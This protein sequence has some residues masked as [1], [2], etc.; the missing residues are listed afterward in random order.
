MTGEYQNFV[1]LRKTELDQ[2]INLNKRRLELQL[3]ERENLE[4]EMASM[5]AD[6]NRM[7]GELNNMVVKEG[8]NADKL[9][10]L[11]YTNII[12]QKLSHYNVLNQHLINLKTLFES[13]RS[14]IELLETK[15]RDIENIKLIQSPVG[16][17]YPIK[18]K[19][20]VSVATALIAGFLFSI[21]LSFFIEYIQKMKR[22]PESSPNSI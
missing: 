20:K 6:T 10:L 4:K 2:K 12:Q 18:P 8:S 14:E 9:S 13:I 11:I 17:I 22:H 15:K 5:N 21:F 3:F 19:R 1:D 7:S 16:S